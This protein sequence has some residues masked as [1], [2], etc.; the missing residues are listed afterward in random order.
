MS[1]ASDEL[2][3]LVKQLARDEVSGKLSN[4][5]LGYISSYDVE[6]ATAKIRIPSL[7]NPDGS[8]FVSPPIPVGSWFTGKVGQFCSG[9]QVYPDT[10]TP[11]E[12]NIV[13]GGSGLSV[14][15]TLTWNTV[16]LPPFSDNNASALALPDLSPGDFGWFHKIGSYELYTGDGNIVQSA[17][18]NYTLLVGAKDFIN[19]GSQAPTEYYVKGTTYRQN[20][21]AL[22]QLI[23]DFCE[24][25]IPLLVTWS[26]AANALSG[27]A[28]DPAVATYAL[29]AGLGIDALTE[30]FTLFKTAVNQFE[31]HGAQFGYLSET[32]RGV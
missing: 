6:S 5:L 13:S 16:Y 30:A 15:A 7:R 31:Q 23:V 9:A 24:Q 2:V 32:I 19:L 20:E 4:N 21:I 12:I 1:A 17:N 26:K 3:L 11:C 29:A 27:A 8:D 28:I 10:D 25:V 14:C 22:N 18:K